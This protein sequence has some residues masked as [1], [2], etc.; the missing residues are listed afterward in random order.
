MLI[1]TGVGPV[2]VR[3]ARVRDRSEAGA[4]EK[5]RLSSPILPKWA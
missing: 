1:Q 2:E 3:R 4:A 5:I